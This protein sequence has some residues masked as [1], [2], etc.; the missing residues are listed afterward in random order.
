MVTL[1]DTLF[2]LCERVG[3]RILLTPFDT[4]WMWR[5]WRWHPYN[6]RHGGCIEHPSELLTSPAARAAI[7]GRLR[8]AVERW[9][10]SGALFAWDLWNEIHPAQA[11]DSA[12]CF[13]EFIESLSRFVRGL[14]QR[15]YGRSHPQTVSLFGPE[16]EWRPHMP[17]KDPIFRH[18]DLDFASIHIYE[19][20]TIDY[21][22]NTVDPALA[23]GRIV[24]AALAEI[25]DGRPFLDSE[26]GPIHSFKDHHISLPEPFDDEYFRHM[27]WAHVASGGAGGGM[28]WPNRH[29]HVL[30]H[31]MRRAQL[32]LAGFLPLID[33]TRFRR[34]NVN[35][36][37]EVST[38][39]VAAL[40]CADDAQAFVWLLRRDTIRPDGMLDRDAAPIPLRIRVPRVAAG[41]ARAT[42][43]DTRVGV[44]RGA[45]E[46]VPDPDGMLAVQIPALTTDLALAIRV[47]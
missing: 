10:G 15:L 39:A 1:W 47:G 41:R 38:P 26:H 6:S 30:T 44:Q 19:E 27:Q 22:R 3:M 42:V 11:R 31:G 40:G 8:F 33:W 2:A 36:E 29:P 5:H 34:A 9:G 12:D 4:F 25:R 24:R 46:A 43:W 37:I 7:K 45:L 18:P 32:A 17:L 23:V 21:P 14:E 20:G 16:L 28:R 35:A 13:G